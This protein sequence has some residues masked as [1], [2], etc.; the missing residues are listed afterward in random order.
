MGEKLGTYGHLI[1]LVRVQAGNFRIENSIKLEDIETS[2]QVEKNLIYP[3][4][5][6]DYQ[7]YELTQNELE[8]VSHG[9]QIKPSAK[10]SD[11]IVILTNNYKLIAA[12]EKINDIIKTSKVFI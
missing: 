11:G 4:K 8:K 6:L 1:K 9:M 5:Y 12:G 2:E 7:K 10:L 3:L